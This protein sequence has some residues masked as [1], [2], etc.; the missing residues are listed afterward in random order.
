MKLIGVVTISTAILLSCRPAV[1]AEDL[2]ELKSDIA[3]VQSE[4]QAS[5]TEDARY[6]GGL[7]KTLIAARIAILRQTEAM[8][9]QKLLSLK[10]G[11]QVRYNVDGKAFNLPATAK[12]MLAGVAGE[13]AGTEEKI[14]QQEAEVARFSGGLAQA[15][16]LATLE[17]MRQTQAMLEQKRVSLKYALPQYV[18][19][20]STNSKGLSTDA[21]SDAA[22]ITRE[23][24]SEASAGELHKVI[25]LSVTDKGFVPSNPRARQYQDLITIKCAYQNTSAK[26][27]RAFTGTVVFQDLFGK[28]IFK[29]GITISSPIAAGQKATWDGT[30]NYNQFMDAHQRLRGTELRDMNVVWLPA[31][32]ILADGTKLGE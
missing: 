13:L 9:Q 18:G 21:T 10:L 26:D 25:A 17:T 2:A 1:R 22:K 23:G 32:I 11:T 7:V 24:T 14:R 3:I 31:S 30:I 4:V 27:V 16:S 19:F 8:L 12:E 6:S 28:E 20:A 5:Q 15:M 29:S